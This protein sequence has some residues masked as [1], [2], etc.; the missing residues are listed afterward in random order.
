LAI[1]LLDA[2]MLL[3]C[4]WEKLPV[5]FAENT[6]KGRVD[7]ALRIHVFVALGSQSVQALLE[8]RISQAAL[9]GFRI[10]EKPHSPGAIAPGHIRVAQGHQ[11]G[12]IGP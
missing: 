5:E 2:F 11:S 1:F 9:V 7:R 10:I 8:S 4:H 3:L 6:A 12:R